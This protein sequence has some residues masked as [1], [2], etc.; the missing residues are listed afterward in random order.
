MNTVLITGANRGLGLEFTKSYLNTG[1][2]VIACCRNPDKAD[3]L[4]ALQQNHKVKLDIVKLDVSD[5]KAI[6]A[7]PH[8]LPVSHIDLLINNAGMFP[9]RNPDQS[10]VTLGDI[11]ADT[12]SKSFHINTFAPLLI[13][14]A[15]LPL[16]EKGTDKTIINITSKLSSIADNTEGSVYA[17]RSAKSALNSITKT[18]SIDLKSKNIKVF[19]FHP[20]WVQ[21]RM[22]E[23]NAKITVDESIQGMLNTLSKLSLED[24]GGF[25]SYR[26]EILKY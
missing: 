21:T 17:Y 11:R 1:S 3:D 23:E 9:D 5:D 10:W 22:G 20:G 7:L 4:H 15:L 8:N 26:N 2:H 6:T 12:L 25:F 24:S 13:T 14:Q 16:I 19:A 18:L